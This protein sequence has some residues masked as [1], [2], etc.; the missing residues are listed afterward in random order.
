MKGRLNSFFAVAGCGLGAICFSMLY[1]TTAAESLWIAGL[2]GVAWLLPWQRLITLGR[3]LWLISGGMALLAGI[4]VLEISAPNIALWQWILGWVIVLLL[5][6]YFGKTPWY[7]TAG[8][9]AV[10]FAA[11]SLFGFCGGMSQFDG[12]L[13]WD[14]VSFS[15]IATG[16]V[17]LLGSG[18]A[19][20][21]IA[22]QKHAAAAG[23]IAACVVWLFN[24][25]VPLLMWSHQALSVLSFPLRS[26]WQRLEI[27]GRFSCGDALLCAV[28]G[29]GTLWQ[30][31]G[32]VLILYKMFPLQK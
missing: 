2:A 12:V 26:S 17:V 15:R 27:F 31:I 19:A 20:Y 8:V 29:V 10:L 30:C 21:E 7:K 4:T 5:G 13:E 22:P 6:V 3:I 16:V 9:V 25:A 14:G 18:L 11:V 1:P 24:A 32:C 23:G 28:A